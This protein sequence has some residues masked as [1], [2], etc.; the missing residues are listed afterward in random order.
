MLSK[1]KLFNIKRPQKYTDKRWGPGFKHEYEC[2]FILKQVPNTF[3]NGWNESN[4]YQKCLESIRKALPT[5]LYT[6]V[7]DLQEES[8][9]QSCVKDIEVG[10]VVEFIQ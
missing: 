7:V 5:D 6:D 4:A 8:F 9:I 3:R 1:L 10:F 2:N